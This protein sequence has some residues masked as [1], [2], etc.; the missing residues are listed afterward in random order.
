MLVTIVVTPRMVGF[1]KV[2]RR[3]RSPFLFCRSRQVYSEGNPG[4]WA[5][6]PVAREQPVLHEALC[7][8]LLEQTPVVASVLGSAL[9]RERSFP[10]VS[11]FDGRG[12]P[13]ETRR[14]VSCTS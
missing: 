12:Y 1:I 9:S 2:Y 6:I 3:D 10:F 14:C 13:P 11:E 4:V 7:T 5:C 8:F